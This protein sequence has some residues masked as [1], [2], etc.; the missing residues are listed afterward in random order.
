MN[1][2][3]ILRNALFVSLPYTLI[4]I[5]I[6]ILHDYEMIFGIVERNGIWALVSAQAPNFLTFYAYIFFALLIQG[7]LYER[8]NHS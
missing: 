3:S 8:K 7:Y 2:F 4:I 5:S 6:T 1:Y